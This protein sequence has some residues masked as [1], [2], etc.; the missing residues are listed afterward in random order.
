MTTTPAMY[1]NDCIKI[2]SP[3]SKILSTSRFKFNVGIDKVRDTW[4]EGAI[5]NGSK[6]SVMEFKPSF[7]ELE[8]SAG[9]GCKCCI[10]FVDSVRAF[11]E[12]T[13]KGG[14]LFMVRHTSEVGIDVER[15]GGSRSTVYLPP[16]PE[17]KDSAVA[18]LGDY[19]CL[20]EEATPLA[21]F[22]LCIQ[23]K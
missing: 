6:P 13:P 14:K 4:M 22:N 7:K 18:K 20:Y 17:E 3:S 16:T 9:R 19:V 12:A 15:L 5:L 10:F 1:C 23:G 2:A 8:D 11:E 21:R